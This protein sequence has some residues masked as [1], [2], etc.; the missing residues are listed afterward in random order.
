[1]ISIREIQE[2][3]IDV[4][5]KFIHEDFVERNFP[6][7]KEKLRDAHKKWYKFI[8]NSDNYVFY[9][10][11]D[12][13]NNF[14]G[15]VRYE[16]ENNKATVSIF[17]SK[18]NRSKKFAKKILQNTFEKL[19]IKNKNISYI[20]ANILPEN[21]ISINLFEDLNFK[22]IDEETYDGLN[23]LVYELFI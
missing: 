3:D 1:M 9:I 5:Y 21:N 6:Q 19:K 14:I 4:I 23:Y 15:T 17:I 13:K 12:D 8:I 2:D 11:K 7:E 10:S 16:I 22:K 18:E 20:I